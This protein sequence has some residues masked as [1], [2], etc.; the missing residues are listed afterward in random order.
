MYIRVRLNKNLESW[1]YL[2]HTLQVRATQISLVTVNCIKLSFQPTDND[3]HITYADQ[4]QINTFA[5]NNARL[6]DIKEELENKKVL[7]NVLLIV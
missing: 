1:I 2:W 7:T 6:Q 3:V 4:Q 5:R